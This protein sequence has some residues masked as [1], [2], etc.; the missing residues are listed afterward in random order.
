MSTNDSNNTESDLRNTQ[1]DYAQLGVFQHLMGLQ[2]ENLNNRR[3]RAMGDA[4]LMEHFP[5]F[6]ED[7]NRDGEDLRFHSNNE[8]HHHYHGAGGSSAPDGGAS[9]TKSKLAKTLA[10]AA[11]MLA[12]GSVG[13]LGVWAASEWFNG[14]PAPVVNTEDKDTNTRYDL[15][16]EGEGEQPPPSWGK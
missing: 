13:G 11:M 12:T 8:T 5:A 6:K 7:Y 14:D 2:E 1:R 9:P 4:Q 15:G 16:L 3:M 10:T